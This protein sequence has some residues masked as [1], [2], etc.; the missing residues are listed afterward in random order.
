MFLITLLLN[1]YQV[2]LLLFI[3]MLH[4]AYFSAFYVNNPEILDSFSNIY[5]FSL[6]TNMNV[7]VAFAV[8][9]NEHFGYNLQ[10][11]LPTRELLLM[12]YINFF[13]ILIIYII[14]VLMF[15]ILSK[16]V[17]RIFIFILFKLYIKIK[18]LFKSSKGSSSLFKVSFLIKQKI[19]VKSF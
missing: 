19:S 2:L 12:D 4:L 11:K 3:K 16:F 5:I 7:F 14:S 15:G 6:E 9:L 18:K 1:F 10:I 13:L 17:V 8:F